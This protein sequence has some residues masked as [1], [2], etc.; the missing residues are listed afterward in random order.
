MVVTDDITQ[1]PGFGRAIVRYLVAMISSLAVF[2]GYLWAVWD[3]RRQTWH[4]KAAGTVV[5]S[6]SKRIQ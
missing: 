1:S 6:S 4:D 5:I 2:L 3:E